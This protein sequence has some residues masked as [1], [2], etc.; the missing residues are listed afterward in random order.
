MGRMGQQ[1]STDRLI[2]YYNCNAFPRLI[3]RNNT[4]N[5]RRSLKGA[6]SPSPFKEVR[7]NH[8]T[9]SYSDHEWQASGFLIP[10]SSHLFLHLP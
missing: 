9:N 4:A 5:K 6:G 3:T 7:L 10:M 8:E 1:L 2:Y